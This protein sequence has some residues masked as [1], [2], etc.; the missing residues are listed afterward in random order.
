M[1]VLVMCALKVYT[2]IGGDYFTG[3][4][5]TNI[6]EESQ[7]KNTVPEDPWHRKKQ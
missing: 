6:A 2:Y 1:V 3:E 7:A 4:F 5:H